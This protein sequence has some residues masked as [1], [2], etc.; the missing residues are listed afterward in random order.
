[1]RTDPIRTDSCARSSN[2]LFIFGYM[3]TNFMCLLFSTFRSIS[4]W[5]IDT[6]IFAK[7]D[8]HPL[9]MKHLPPP[10]SNVLEINKPPPPGGLNRGFMVFVSDA[11]ALN[12]WVCRSLSPLPVMTA[13]SSRPLYLRSWSS[14]ALVTVEPSLSG[15]SW[16]M[17]NWPHK[18]IETLRGQCAVESIFCSFTIF[19]FLNNSYVS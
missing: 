16:G 4:L 10:S 11:P 6:I 12:W 18:K 3:T 9:S 5:G 17:A 7:L 2:L 13:R 15:Y 1:M 8:K 14:C 19:I